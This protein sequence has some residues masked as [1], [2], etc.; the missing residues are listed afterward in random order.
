[1][2]SQPSKVYKTDAQLKTDILSELEFEP[3]VKATDIGVLVKDGTVTLN[4]YATSY[5]EKYNA[6]T[7][8]KRV[9]G[10]TAIA[11]D[12]EVKFPDS[13]RRTDGDIAA[14]ADAAIKWSTSV[15]KDSVQVIVRDGWIT[16]EGAVEWWYQ[17]NSAEDLV[18][19]LS[20]VAGV[21]N[22]IA[23]KPVLS[24]AD[25]AVSIK[26]AFERSSLLDATKIQVET[27]GSQVTLRG[28][29]RNYAER[30][31]AERVAW[32]APGAYS[33]DNQISVSWF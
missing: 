14:T 12:I 25:I 3:S 19:Y 13:M 17:R 21:S 20:G 5:G 28:K 8:T 2:K 29:V 26:A 23:I 1:M 4:G 30:E 9:A 11:D 24:A 33:V 6:V 22:N 7:A 18:Q 31:E 15:P 10:V 16:L 27:S 32:A